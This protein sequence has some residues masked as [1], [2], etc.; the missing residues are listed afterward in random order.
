MVSAK[1]KVENGEYR[2]LKGSRLA[3]TPTPSCPEAIKKQR[4]QAK[5]VDS[6]GVLTKDIVFSSPS[7][8][9]QFVLYAS[10]NGKTAWK[11]VSGNTLE[12]FLQKK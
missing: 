11:D 4:N 2:I 5:E 12:S 8:A 7:G 1:L 10:A 6:K 9:A 3:I